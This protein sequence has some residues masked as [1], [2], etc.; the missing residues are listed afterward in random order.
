MTDPHAVTKITDHNAYSRN[1][2][3]KEYQKSQ[4]D[5][6]AR[7]TLDTYLQQCINADYCQP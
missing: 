6:I 5:G 2:S 3:Y 7:S 1:Y 4:I